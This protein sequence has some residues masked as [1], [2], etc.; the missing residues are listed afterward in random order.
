MK[1]RI[2]HVISG[3]LTGGA[4]WMMH[5][6]LRQL[7]GAGFEH[8][9]V[10]LASGDWPM[11]ARIESLGIPVIQCAMR[12]GL[13]GPLASAKAIRVIRD[14]RPDVLQ[15]WMYHGNLAALAAG[16][17]ARIPVPVIWN[18]VATVSDLRKSKLSTALAIRL[19][20]RLSGRPERIVSDSN[21]S[22]RIHQ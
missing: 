12:P 10:S 19:G 15:G 22:A 3:L 7:S 2:V 1:I 5:K 18:I 16:A 20:A 11:T 4:E 14:Q 13:P 6:L 9:V 8:A 17:S 21:A